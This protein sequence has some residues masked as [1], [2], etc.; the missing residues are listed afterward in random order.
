MKLKRAVLF[1]III[2]FALTGLRSVKTSIPVF[3]ITNGIKLP[4]LMYHSICSDASKTGKYVLTPKAFEDDMK[5]LKNQGYTAISA[6]QLIKYVYLGEDLPEKPIILTFDDG[7]YNNKEYVLPILEK[8]DFCAVFSIVG[9]Y[10]DE[11]TENN[12]VNPDYS[13]LRWSDICLLSENPR[14]EFG[15]HSYAFHSISRK[16]YGTKKNKNESLLDYINAFYQDT[17]KLQSKFFSSCNFKPV[18]YTYPFGSYSKESL[19]VLKKMGFLVTF[20]CFEGVNT[21][22]HDADCLFML[23]RYNR[24]GRISTSAFFSK[25]KL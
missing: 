20:S 5:Y 22:T 25:L 19:R 2:L 1:L 13:Y 9:S 18:I 11:Y 24:D 23:K 3:N 16:R 4:V 6:K 14:I 21:I 15:N 12:I 10:T 8:Y 7:M 17:E